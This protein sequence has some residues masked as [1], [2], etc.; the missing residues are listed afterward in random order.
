[1]RFV[2]RKTLSDAISANDQSNTY[3]GYDYCGLSD[4]GKEWLA[5]DGGDGK[6]YVG[7][8]KWGGT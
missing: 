6:K 7:A 3:Y 2:L 1:M 5:A 4:P 8:C